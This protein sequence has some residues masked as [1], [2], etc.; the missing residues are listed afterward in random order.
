MVVTNQSGLARGKYT[1]AEFAAVTTRL[2]ELLAAEGVLPYRYAEMTAP[3]GFERR[4]VRALESSQA[5]HFFAPAGP[6]AAKP[7]AGDAGAKKEAPAK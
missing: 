6:G 5:L 2:A 1:A 7:V 4:R 3:N